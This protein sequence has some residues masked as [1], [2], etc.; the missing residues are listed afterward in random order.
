MFFYAF[1]SSK[2]KFAPLYA[3]G[4]FDPAVLSLYKNVLQKTERAG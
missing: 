3:R 2:L 1:P 4:H